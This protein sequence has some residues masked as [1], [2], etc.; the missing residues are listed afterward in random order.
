MFA[1][2][3]IVD[4]DRY[5]VL[6]SIDRLGPEF[7]SFYSFPLRME[8]SALFYKIEEAEKVLKRLN[9]QKWNVGTLKICKIIVQ[10]ITEEDNEGR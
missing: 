7:C 1:Y 4:D 3:I 8:R 6:R 10:D 5:D 9:R 2:Y